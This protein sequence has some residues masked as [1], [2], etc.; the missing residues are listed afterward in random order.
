MHRHFAIF[1]SEIF[2]FLENEMMFVRWKRKRTKDILKK[3]REKKKELRN[4]IDIENE[5]KIYIS[6]KDK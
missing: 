6:L 1:S 5:K 3:E 4:I 2:I